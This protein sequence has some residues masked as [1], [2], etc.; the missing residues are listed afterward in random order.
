M[1]M[2]PIGFVVV[3]FGGVSGNEVVAGSEIVSHG[4]AT[5]VGASPS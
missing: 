3:K 5:R 2:R 4:P 1:S